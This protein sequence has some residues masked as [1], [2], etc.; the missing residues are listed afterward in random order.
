MHKFS[1]DPFIDY[2]ASVQLGPTLLIFFLFGLI[3]AKL[4]LLKSTQLEELS[5][6]SENP[7]TTMARVVRMAP[8]NHAGFVYGYRVGERKYQ[9]FGWHES[10]QVGQEILICYS[11]GNP[12]CSCVYADLDK[13]RG[14]LESHETIGSFMFA[15]WLAFAFLDWRKKH[16]ERSTKLLANYLGLHKTSTVG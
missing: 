13:M 8:E 14:N 11:K 6:L 4:S 5:A 2:F 9:G 7:S 1:W 10:I 3:Y 16:K 15:S 12:Q